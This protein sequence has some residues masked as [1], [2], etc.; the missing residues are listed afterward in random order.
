MV[1]TRQ[2]AFIRDFAVRVSDNRSR[3]S[4]NDRRIVEYLRE[5]PDELAFHT[6]KSL[7]VGVGVSQAAV[8]RLARKLGYDGFTELRDTARQD[9]RD[10]GPTLTARFSERGELS[11]EDM[12]R[13]DVDNLVATQSFVEAE[14]PRAARSIAGAAAVYVVGDRE[15]LGLAV[16]QRC[17]YRMYVPPLFLAQRRPAEAGQVFGSSDRS[18]H[19]YCLPRLSNRDGSCPCSCHGER[20]LPLEHGR[21]RSGPGGLGGGGRGRLSR[22]DPPT[23]GNDRPVQER[24]RLLLGRVSLVRPCVAGGNAA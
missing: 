10:G 17:G 14:L 11:T 8:I 22:R 3:L 7:A 23:T 18:R 5:H 19:G 15:T 12:F 21:S 9:L 13:Q 6:S 16:F 20:P 24:A 2:R 4:N 1:A